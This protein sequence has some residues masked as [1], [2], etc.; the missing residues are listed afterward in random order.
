MILSCKVWTCSLKIWTFILKYELVVP[1]YK[2]LVL[3]YELIVPKYDIVVA[4]YEI[5]VP[6]Y[7]IAVPKYYF[8]IPIFICRRR[9]HLHFHPDTAVYC[10]PL[11]YHR[12]SCS[13]ALTWERDT[14]LEHEIV[15]SISVPHPVSIYLSGSNH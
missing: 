13:S 7:Y 4:K 10:L 8:A 5:L 11:H 14:R 9:C 6:K 12:N 2:L 1:K 15:C 3:K